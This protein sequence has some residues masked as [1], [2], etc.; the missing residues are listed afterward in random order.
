V[1]VY[2]CERGTPFRSGGVR[3]ERE[4]E[5]GW[6]LWREKRKV[7]KLSTRSINFIADKIKH[8][9]E[10]RNKRAGKMKRENESNKYQA[11]QNF[12][13]PDF[14]EEESDEESEMETMRK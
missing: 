8:D 14:D 10:E 3:R 1:R 13:I 12:T 4:G 11:K 5:E 9:K 2:A 7:R 6:C